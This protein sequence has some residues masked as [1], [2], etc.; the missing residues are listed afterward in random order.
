MLASA[1]E[2]RGY[3]CSRALG[4]KTAAGR[5]RW[6]D[7]GGRNRRERGDIA[8][9]G[10]EASVWRCHEVSALPIGSGRLGTGT[11]APAYLL[12]SLPRRQAFGAA[13]VDAF[14]VPSLNN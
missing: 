7:S 11:G 4:R 8:G 6:K 2:G 1:Y 5:K 3:W 9:S 12:G 10:P 13:G 14:S